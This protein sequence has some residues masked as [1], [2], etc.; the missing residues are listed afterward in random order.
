[1][2]PSRGAPEVA[3]RMPS[4]G[5]QE[6]AGRMPSR[7]AQEIAPITEASVR[8]D[9]RDESPPPPPPPPP[10]AQQQAPPPR[11]NHSR[12]DWAN[13]APPVDNYPGKPP[14]PY[15]HG[16]YPNG[17][18][19]GQP[20]TNLLPSQP[21]SAPM[22]PNGAYQNPAPAPAPAASTEDDSGGVGI[23][24]IPNFFNM[25]A[26]LFGQRPAAA[27][28]QVPP[29]PPAAQP[30]VRGFAPQLV[31]QASFQQQRVPSSAMSFSVPAG[32]GMPQAVP[33]GVPPGHVPSF[34][35][36]PQMVPGR[37][38]SFTGPPVAPSGSRR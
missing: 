31:A 13:H 32:V 36:A 7:G 34:T 18:Y 29:G 28:L 33:A 23:G 38:Y 17:S 30:G 24:L 8:R 11:S 27:S 9:D 3:G 16:A 12:D 35:V 15:P 22:K 37:G 10:K 20:D 19:P 25:P 26:T 1:M 2:M 14:E 4:R 21:M 6:A 5:A